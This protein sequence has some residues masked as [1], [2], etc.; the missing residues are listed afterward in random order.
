MQMDSLFLWQG[1]VIQWI[2]Q[3]WTHVHW[4][5]TEHQLEWKLGKQHIYGDCSAYKSKA[6]SWSSRIEDLG[7]FSTW[8]W[9]FWPICPHTAGVLDSVECSKISEVNISAFICR[10]FHADISS[11]VGE[12][13][14]SAFIYRLF[15]G[16]FSSISS[17]ANVSAFIYRLFHEDFSSLVGEANLSTFIYRLF[18]GNFSSIVSETNLSAFIYR[19]LHE[20]S[21]QSVVKL[22]YLHW[23]TN[24]FMKILLHRWWSKFICIYLQTVSWRYLLNC[25]WS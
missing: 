2:N 24:S 23:F 4:L 7:V 6:H 9:V 25:R 17:E 11:I 13:H 18:H 12:F 19:L 22:I 16:D 1:P 15:H 5:L 14:L 20:Y 10:L 8:I 21:P 3:R